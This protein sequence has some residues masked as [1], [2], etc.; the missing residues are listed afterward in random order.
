MESSQAGSSVL[1]R[2]TRCPAAAFLSALRLQHCGEPGS[3]CA[4]SRDFSS[5][6]VAQPYAVKTVTIMNNAFD[7]L[8]V[9]Y[10]MPSDLD[11][12]I[13]A[14]PS[15]EVSHGIISGKLFAHGMDPGAPFPS[16]HRYDLTTGEQPDLVPIH[17][18]DRQ[19]LV[20]CTSKT[21][22]GRCWN[23]VA[24]IAGAGQRANVKW[25]QICQ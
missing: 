23:S 3:P 8:K 14:Q 17:I 13:A 7:C 9:H 1:A 10:G 20:G 2:P 5:E 19:Q 12:R 21:H 16:Q 4:R 6:S 22:F 11:E 18:L 15:Q 25:P 24:A